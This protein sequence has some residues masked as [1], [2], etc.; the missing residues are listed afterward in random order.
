MVDHVGAE[1]AG[2][3]LGLDAGDELAARRA[4]HRDL[5]LGEAL[6]ELLDDLL[7]DLGEVGRVVGERAFLL[8]RLDQ[9]LGAELAPAPAPARPA[10]AAASAEAGGQHVL[11]LYIRFPPDYRRC[12]PVRA[13]PWAAPRE[14]Q[15]VMPEQHGE[16]RR[17]HQAEGGGLADVAALV[18]VEQQHGH[19][20]R[21]A[22]VEKERGAELADRQHEQQRHRGDDAGPRQRQH[23]GARWC[24][25]GRGRRSRPP[26][27]APCGSAGTRS[28][29]PSPCRG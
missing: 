22:G 29:A 4:H 28:T 27:R 12:Q 10:N 6:V 20:G 11:R 9:L 2:G 16:D 15:L 13:L 7:L 18:I 3:R 24:R 1:L 21:V 26:P 14:S 23:D 25:A 8:G 5:D 19:H 17:L